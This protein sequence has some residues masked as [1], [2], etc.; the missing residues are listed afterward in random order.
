MNETRIAAIW[1]RKPKRLIDLKEI[2]MKTQWCFSEKPGAYPMRWDIFAINGLRLDMNQYFIRQ[3]I[4]LSHGFSFGLK[5]QR[6]CFDSKK[7]P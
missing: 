4:L 3:K 2:L 1:Y 6:S 5:R 7:L